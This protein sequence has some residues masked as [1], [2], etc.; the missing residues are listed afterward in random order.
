MEFKERLRDL[1]LKKG[2]KSKEV[3]KS[4]GIP[5]PTYISYESR[6][7][8]PPYEVLCKNDGQC[9]DLWLWHK[10]RKG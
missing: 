1:R 10:S 4:V 9:A 5:E 8:Q 6:G 7:S 2:M 3:A